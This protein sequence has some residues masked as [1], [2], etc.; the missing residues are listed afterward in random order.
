MSRLVLCE[1]KLKVLDL[2]PYDIVKVDMDSFCPYTFVKLPSGLR[3]FKSKLVS[4]DY[5]YEDEYEEWINEEYIEN[6]QNSGTKCLSDMRAEVRQEMQE[7]LDD[8]AEQE[9]LT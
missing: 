8:I 9:L 4:D 2:D 6:L 1:L 7:I 5:D 3:K